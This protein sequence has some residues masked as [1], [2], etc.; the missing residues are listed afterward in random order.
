MAEWKNRQ[1]A[2]AELS[3]NLATVSCKRS[4]FSAP[5]GNTKI[6][7]KIT[8]AH[9]GAI[10]RNNH[11]MLIF[12][13]SNTDFCCISIIAI[14]DQFSRSLRKVFVCAPTENLH[15]PFVNAYVFRPIHVNFL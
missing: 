6:Q 3:N 13:K 7:V 9:A 15:N 5:A 14:G 10:V 2:Y 12:I 4:L 8:F 11:A 1:E